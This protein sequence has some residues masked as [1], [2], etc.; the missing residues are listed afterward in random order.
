MAR[1]RSFVTILAG[2]KEKKMMKK[3]KL[4]RSLDKFILAF[5]LSNK[6]L[7]KWASILEKN[8]ILDTLFKACVAEVH[9]FIGKVIGKVISQGIGKKSRPLTAL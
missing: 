4:C 8:T 7:V 6:N 5:N 2:R 3:I 1:V 9:R